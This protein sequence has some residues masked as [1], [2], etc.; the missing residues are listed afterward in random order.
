MDHLELITRKSLIP[1]HLRSTSKEIIRAQAALLNSE[2]ANS[3]SNPGYLIIFSS[4]DIVDAFRH[5]RSQTRRK[6]FHGESLFIPVWGLE[7]GNPLISKIERF[8]LYRGDYRGESPCFGLIAM[9]DWW[10]LLDTPPDRPTKHVDGA[11]IFY[12]HE[13]IYTSTKSGAHFYKRNNKNVAPIGAVMSEDRLIRRYREPQLDY[14]R[15]PR[16]RSR[17]GIKSPR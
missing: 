1:T 10:C 7:S 5:M 12:A 17:N 3:A 13:E 6:L 8:Q 15:R 14:S 9:D 11:R 4:A 2:K 16:N